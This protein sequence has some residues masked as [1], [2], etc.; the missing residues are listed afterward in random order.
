MRTSRTATCAIILAAAA[1]VYA[2]EYAQFPGAATDSRTLRFKEKVEDIY[3]SGNYER[4]MLIYQKELAPKGDKYAQYMVGYMHLTGRGVAEDPAEALAWYRLAAERGEPK[5]IEARDELYQSL[6]SGELERSEAL[7]ADLWQRYGDKRLILEL[8]RQD[9]VILS[10]QGGSGVARA[11]SDAR[12]ASGY[13]IS[14]DGN[15]YHR[16]VRTQLAERIHYLRTM[17]EDPPAAAEQSDIDAL[18]ESVR[19]ELRDLELP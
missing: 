9:L 7:F 3:S 12:I 2:E 14:Q 4:A 15:P 17:P 5:Y 18:E 16:R 19:R 13:S 8:I 6:D 11:N 10:V 1:F